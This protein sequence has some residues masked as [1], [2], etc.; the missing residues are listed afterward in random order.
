VIPAGHRL[1]AYRILSP[2][3]AGGMG[4]VYLAEDTRLHRRVALK[5]LPPRAAEDERSH[6]R[7]LR[8]A[9]AAAALDH[10]NICTVYD[11]GE[12]EGHSFIA[13]QYVEGETLAAR[14][15]QPLDLDVAL[16]I[17]VQVAAALAEAHRHGI[18]HRDIKPQNIM[19]SGGG[20]V[21]VLDFGLARFT[22]PADGTAETVTLLTESGAIA[23][24][25][26]YMSPEQTRGDPLDARSDV[27]SFGCVFYEMLARTHPF[28]GRTAAETISAILTREPAALPDTI[29][30]DEVQRILRK[31]LEKNRER[32]YQTTADLVIDLEN[33]RSGRHAPARPPSGATVSAPPHRQRRLLRLVWI[34]APAALVVLAAGG[35]WWWSVR[36]GETTVPVPSARFVQITNLADSAAAPSLSPDGRM[37]AFV[38]GGE[39]FNS[40]GQVYVKLLPNGDA[41][42]L[43]N[44]PRP[45]YA[46]A[47]TPDGSRVAY[48]LVSGS[49]VSLSWDTW[50]VPVLG[51]KP[52]LLLPN[53]S[54]L[55][56][57]DGSHVVFSEI[58]AG[59]G[60]HM[61]IVTATVDRAS[62]RRLYFPQNQRAMAH[63]SYPSPDRRWVLVVE[64]DSTLAWQRC[65]LVP[66]DGSSTGHAVG[67]T[68]ACISAGWSPDG[69]WMYFSAAVEGRF[70]LWRQRFPDGP[71]EPLTSESATEERGITVAPD[72]QSLITAVGQRQDSLWVHDARGDHLLPL[73]GA[74]SDPRVS[75]DGT[76]VYCLVQQA[77]APYPQG[78]TVV[79]LASGRTDRI[80]AEFPIVNFDIS[81]DDRT[82]AFTTVSAGGQHQV[83]R[84]DLDRRSPPAEVATDADGVRFGAGGE[85]IIRSLAARQNTLERIPE[86]TTTAQRI[87]TPPLMDYL[88][89]SPD[90]TWAVI[91]TADPSRP[92][93]LETVAVPV[94][95]GQAR[96]LC[97][98]VCWPQWSQDGRAFYL[99][100]LTPASQVGQADMASAGIGTL[101]FRLPAG[102][103][104]PDL[105]PEGVSDPASLA[106]R[107]GVIRIPVS[108]IAP[109]PDPSLY[110]FQRADIQS[111]LFRVPLR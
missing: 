72:G 34:I 59:T 98:K 55:A 47:F 110:V 78:V 62:E 52:T 37:V 32:R 71:P 46:P 93:G 29:A 17:A 76:R 77:T 14:L 39:W 45:K 6:K 97:P 15:R 92:S 60:L 10:P 56:W 111:N 101:V 26:P 40:T 36:L 66:L 1:G 88:A 84:A 96:V 73:E 95:G 107:P 64:M 27:F 43:T 58:E 83:W 4:E 44:D 18:I 104:F 65:R 86:G 68:G 94:D 28:H 35:F 19:L 13:M 82:V 79:D 48:T 63:L 22:E 102:R 80:L 3:G 41:V 8:E 49:G 42:R 30:P 75:R 89:V 24:T 53:A 90:G 11:V 33:A 2:L 16:A 67:P 50:T 106:A 69:R 38:S 108:D 5:L 54:G 103:V 57:L 7:L 87:V 85:L 91:V 51:G 70:H 12:A 9:Q 99:M 100:D 23:G 74:A 31:C 109:G 105:P 20:Q 61:G 81:R 21:K 25:V